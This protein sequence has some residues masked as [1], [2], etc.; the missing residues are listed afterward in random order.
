MTKSLVNKDWRNINYHSKHRQ[1][2]EDGETKNRRGVKAK[3]GNEHSNGFP[4]RKSQ[5]HKN[6]TTQ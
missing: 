1:Q 6:G 5:E 4:R 3:E 2:D